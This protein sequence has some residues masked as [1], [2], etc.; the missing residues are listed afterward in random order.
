MRGADMNR[1]RYLRAY[2][3]GIV[4]PTMF[5]LVAMFAFTTARYVYNVPIQIERVIVF[6][7]A[8]IPNFWGIW[9]MLYV[10]L[11][12]TYQAPI[13]L[14]GAA[15]VVLIVPIGFGLARLLGFEFPV[16]PLAIAGAPAALV[17]YYLV[18]KYIVSFLNRLLEIP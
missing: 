14:H 17:A 11:S 4:V 5:L 18:W 2:M 1:H 13:G 3:C 16:H 8:L 9:N 15:L 10:R 6:P 12:E 7:M